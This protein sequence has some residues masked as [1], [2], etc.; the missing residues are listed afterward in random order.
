MSEFETLLQA[1]IPFIQFGFIAGLVIAVVIAAGKI[2]F[3]LAPYIIVG[4]AL[5]YFFG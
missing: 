4:A 3:K 1:L 2:G 5:I